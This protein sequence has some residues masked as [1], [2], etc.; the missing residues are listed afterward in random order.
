[1]HPR[2]VSDVAS[3]RALARFVGIIGTPLLSVSARQQQ[4]RLSHSLCQARTRLL[5]AEVLITRMVRGVAT[6]ALVAALPS[7][8]GITGSDGNNGERGVHGIV[9]RAEHA[10]DVAKGRLLGPAL[11]EGPRGLAFEVQDGEAIVRLEDLAQ[12]VVAMAADLVRPRA[13]QEPDVTDC[14][15]DVIRRAP[16]R[17]AN[18]AKTGKRLRGDRR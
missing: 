2:A 3:V 9:Q 10:R 6:L 17:L 16:E 13:S 14:G 1:M 4:S 12:V 18:G 11:L 5:A 8:D 15:I 7:R